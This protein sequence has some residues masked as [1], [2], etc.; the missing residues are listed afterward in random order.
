MKRRPLARFVL[1][2]MLL[3]SPLAML[4]A[5]TV[6]GAIL[7]GSGRYH[8]GASVGVCLLFDSPRA[9]ARL[10]ELQG[11]FLDEASARPGF[12]RFSCGAY[13]TEARAHLEELTKEESLAPDLTETLPLFV[14]LAEELP[15]EGDLSAAVDFLRQFDAADSG[16]EDIFPSGQGYVALLPEELPSANPIDS[17][18]ILPAE[19]LTPLPSARLEALRW[20]AADTALDAALLSMVLTLALAF[21]D[22]AGAALPLARAAVGKWTFFLASLLAGNGA[23]SLVRR[24]IVRES[25]LSDWRCALRRSVLLLI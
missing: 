6:L 2:V 23:V 13:L 22:T 5:I 25:H 19:H 18:F 11:R 4:A 20:R 14:S 8:A 7:P 10:D 16:A 15:D 17:L 9:R 24:V 1:P 12:D 3:L 21:C